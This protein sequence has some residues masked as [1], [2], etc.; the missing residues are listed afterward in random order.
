MPPDPRQTGKALTAHYD[1]LL[2][3]HG[4]T[5]QG[6]GWPNESD[7]QRRFAVMRGLA[8]GGAP[9]GRLCDLA[10]GTGAFLRHLQAAGVAPDR[11]LGID[12]SGTAIARARALHAGQT[13]VAFLETDILTAPPAERFD[14]IVAN[15]LFTV[16][17]TLS[18]EAMWIFLEATVRAMWALAD[19]GI[20]FN[21][22]SAVVDWRRDDLFH[23]PAD[24]LLALLHGIAGR[25]VVLRADYDLWEMTAYVWRDPPATRLTGLP[26]AG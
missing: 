7:R 14:H 13:N 17:A 12:L 21:V 9:L 19:R 26:S 10:C 18:E 23:V 22:M 6:A 8:W 1:A 20:A 11:Y 3:V 16:R 2:A 25:R 15:G 5:A 4:D 24:R